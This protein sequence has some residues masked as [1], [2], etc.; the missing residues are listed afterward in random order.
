VGSGLRANDSTNARRR[1]NPAI[2]DYRFGHDDVRRTVDFVQ[3]SVQHR[4]RPVVMSGGQLILGVHDQ[5]AQ[6]LLIDFGLVEPD[7]SLDFRGRACALSSP[8]M[9]TSSTVACSLSF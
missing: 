2:A 1:I 7:E 3:R 6:S 8:L 9:G 4:Q 5:L